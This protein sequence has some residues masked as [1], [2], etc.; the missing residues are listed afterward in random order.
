MQVRFL[1]FFLLLF[2]FNNVIWSQEVPPINVFTTEDYGAQ[3]QNWGIAQGENKFIYV[4]N[5]QGLL[6]YNGASWHLYPTAN[7]SITRSVKSFEGKIYTGSFMDFGYWVRNDFGSLEYTSIVENNN[8]KML[9]D[10]Q[11]W[12]I[13]EF[14]GWLL[15]KSL[16]RIYLYNL[17]TK[18]LKIINASN[19]ITKLSKVGNAI[20]FQEIEKG[21]FMIENG[22][23]KL[24]SSHKVLKENRIVDIFLKNGNNREKR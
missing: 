6:E 14:D 18:S 19:N 5:N 15:F 2:I 11:I 17:K 10:E 23:P 8:I 21:I 22:I 4:A 12:E 20:Y 3:N 24:I 9:E 13:V 16:E 1:K 7:E